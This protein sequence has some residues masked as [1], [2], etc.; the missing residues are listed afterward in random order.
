MFYDTGNEISRADYA[1]GYAIYAFDL[2]PDMCGSSDHFNVSQRGNLAV[3]IMFSTAP[4]AVLSL[5]CYGEF[6]NTI[7]IDAERNVIYDYSG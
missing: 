7:H 4:T 2:T 5:V 1:S 3:D 6:E